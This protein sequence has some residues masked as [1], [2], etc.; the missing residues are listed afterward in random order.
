MRALVAVLGIALFVAGCTNQNQ[1]S[2][3]AAASLAETNNEAAVSE[4]VVT[5]TAA[6]EEEAAETPAEQIG[7]AAPEFE[8]IVGTDDAKHS[9]KDFAD[10]KAVVLVFT[11]NHCPVA[12]AYEDRLIALQKDYESKGVQLVAINVSNLE[13]DKLPAM[14]ER[15]EQKG[16]PYPYLY[17]PTQKVGRDY[18]AAV[19]PHIF[20]LDGE[21]KI[22]YMGPVDDN[23]DESKV[24][25][26]Y[27]RDAIDAVL[28]GSQP[29]SASIKPVGCGITYE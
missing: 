20:L 12:V 23:M 17:D 13:D 22:A 18:G 19:T 6:T 5:Q 16:L 26:K 15:A 2:T 25:V 8:G 10:K 27:L 11:C 29:T 24:S 7:K 3:D 1:P 4:P 21:R 9:L 28:A 14:K